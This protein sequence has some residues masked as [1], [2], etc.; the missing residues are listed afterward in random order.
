MWGTPSYSLE[1]RNYTTVPVILK[2]TN[3][4]ELL[5]PHMRVYVC[6]ALNMPKYK[7]SLVCVM[8]IR[9]YIYTYTSAHPAPTACKFSFLFYF[10]NLYHM[11]LSWLFTTMSQSC[12]TTQVYKIYS[13]ALFK[14]RSVRFFIIFLYVYTY[15]QETGRQQHR[16]NKIYCYKAYPKTVS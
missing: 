5:A 10:A 16:S 11:R 1:T 2:Y 15:R 12:F 7:I 8:Y 4:P 9:Q 6:V 14:Y 3:V 13:V